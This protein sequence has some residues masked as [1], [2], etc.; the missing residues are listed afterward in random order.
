MAATLQIHEARAGL[1]TLDER[2]KRDRVLFV[3]RHGKP[4]FAAVDLDYWEAANDTIEVL[5]DPEAMQMLRD[6]IADIRA[7]RLIDHDDLTASSAATP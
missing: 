3:T 7:G 1:N 6:S 2:L 5:S 4:V